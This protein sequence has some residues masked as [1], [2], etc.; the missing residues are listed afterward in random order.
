MNSARYSCEN[1]SEDI[2]AR[3][4]SMSALSRYGDSS[5]GNDQRSQSVRSPA[6]WYTS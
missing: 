5:E 2:S 1:S 6:D 3:A 4:I